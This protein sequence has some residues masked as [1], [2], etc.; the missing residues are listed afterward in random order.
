MKE[1]RLVSPDPPR[2][3]RLTL[4]DLAVIA[5]LVR[6]SVFWACLGVK[7]GE[8]LWVL[9]FGS[10]GDDPSAFEAEVSARKD[11]GRL[12]SQRKMN[13]Y[14]QAASPRRAFR[15]VRAR[16]PSR[17]SLAPRTK[18]TSFPTG[19]CVPLTILAHMFS[20]ILCC[21][22]LGEGAMT[23][24]APPIPTTRA[25]HALVFQDVFSRRLGQV[26]ASTKAM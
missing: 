9:P 8:P 15:M 23:V 18:P 14:S 20:D 24:A 26:A 21:S 2:R 22:V 25:R 7:D 19:Q 6:V 13:R 12:Y 4:L 3:G 5:T 11:V 1:R 10:L 16:L 17:K